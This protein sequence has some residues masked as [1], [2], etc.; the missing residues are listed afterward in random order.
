MRP[1]AKY[2][3]TAKEWVSF[4]GTAGQ[5]HWNTDY[6]RAYVRLSLLGV[7][8]INELTE[9]TKALPARTLEYKNPDQESM[10]E[11]LNSSRVSLTSEEIAERVELGGVVDINSIVAAQDQY[12]EADE[13]V[14]DVIEPYFDLEAACLPRESESVDHLVDSNIPGF[15]PITGW[16]EDPYLTLLID[17]ME[18]ERES[19]GWG[20]FVFPHSPDVFM[21]DDGRDVEQP[22]EN[23][24]ATDFSTTT[25]GTGVTRAIRATDSTI[26]FNV[27][28]VGNA[29]DAGNNAI[30]ATK[31]PRA[32]SL[33]IY[34]S[35]IN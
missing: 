27:A 17:S 22:P 7:N 15:E 16:K 2:S 8:N 12:Q 11:W 6:A 21:G 19:G 26:P 23:I 30:N 28:N 31:P 29:A 24:E 20:P 18:D 9:C 33:R 34:K 4:L 32:T 35:V 10:D 5:D 14:D 3:T 25:I 13:S 1:L